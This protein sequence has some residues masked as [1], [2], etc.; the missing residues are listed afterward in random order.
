ML[1]VLLVVPRTYHGA[2]HFILFAKTE[3]FILFQGERR[4]TQWAVNWADQNGFVT[5]GLEKRQPRHQ[6]NRERFGVHAC[7]AGAAA[8]EKV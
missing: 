1:V 2:F 8:Q 6:K 5:A 3:R 4:K 7:V